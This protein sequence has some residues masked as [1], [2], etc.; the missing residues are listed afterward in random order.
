[1]RESSA[2][3]TKDRGSL[4]R[5]PLTGGVQG[6]YSATGAFAPP[7][8]VIVRAGVLCKRR[9][10]SGVVLFVNIVDSLTLP[11][12]DIRLCEPCSDWEATLVV[13]L[14]KE[15]ERHLAD[16]FSP[17]RTLVETLMT[18]ASNLCRRRQEVWKQ[19]SQKAPRY[20][21]ISALPLSLFVR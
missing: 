5:I 21:R 9:D 13:S 14:W 2:Y 16:D 17:L 4:D 20:T 11:L 1:M 7:P 8:D 3:G 18:A 12:S 19:N 15:V 10:P 6:G